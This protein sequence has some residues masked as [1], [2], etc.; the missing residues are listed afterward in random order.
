[1]L[2][3]LW[4]GISPISVPKKTM[5][6][7]APRMRGMGTVG[8]VYGKSV[9]SIVAAFIPWFERESDDWKPNKYFGVQPMDMIKS[10]MI[11]PYAT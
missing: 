10:K 7:K 3:A 9:R 8:F 11:F 6:N 5:I 2:T 1:M 4:A